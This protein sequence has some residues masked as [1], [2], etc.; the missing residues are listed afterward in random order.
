MKEIER[1]REREVGSE[2]ERERSCMYVLV[3]SPN[4]CNNRTEQVEIQEPE[5]PLRFPT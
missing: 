2:K 3:L 5:N 1:G 4:D